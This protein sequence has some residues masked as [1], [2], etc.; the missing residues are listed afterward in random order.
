MVIKYV[1]RGEK[2]T[3]SD[4]KKTV[5]AHL[6]DARTITLSQ[7]AYIDTIVK[8]LNLQSTSPLLTPIDPSIHL[9]KDQ[10]HSP[11]RIWG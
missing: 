8:W 9:L 4:G 7:A 5:V 2:V 1:I 3:E 11:H 6:P 10:A